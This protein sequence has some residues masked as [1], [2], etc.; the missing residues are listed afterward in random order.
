MLK[1]INAENTAPLEQKWLIL[2]E[3]G[4]D[5]LFSMPTWLF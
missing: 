5:P 1:P 4:A 3:E 2:V